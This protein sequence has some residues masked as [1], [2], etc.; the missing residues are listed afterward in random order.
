MCELQKNNILAK[1]IKKEYDS[2]IGDG[3]YVTTFYS[4]K[5]LEF[6]NVFIPF[7]NKEDYPDKKNWKI[8]KIKID[9]ICVFLLC[10]FKFL[11][12]GG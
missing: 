4:V 9:F 11:R 8:V 5:G 12:F 6:D 7:L 1:E 10:Q 3:V 2:Y